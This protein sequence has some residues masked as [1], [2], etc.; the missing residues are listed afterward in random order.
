ME[1]AVDL[2]SLQELKKKV[3]W[4]LCLNNPIVRTCLAYYRS[5]AISYEQA[6]LGAIVHL[7]ERSDYLEKELS[8]KN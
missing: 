8:A 4:E 3:E 2:S 6:L 1:N 7:A 5:G